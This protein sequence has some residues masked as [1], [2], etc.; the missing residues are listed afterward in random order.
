MFKIPAWLKKL[1]SWA[2]WTVAPAV[3]TIA[4]AHYASPL[5]SWVA[6][7]YPGLG[8]KNFISTVSKN[9]SLLAAL[10]L[11]VRAW[12]HALYQGVYNVAVYDEPMGPNVPKDFVPREIMDD[13]YRELDRNYN[14]YL[15]GLLANDHPD[16]YR[17]DN[18]PGDEEEISWSGSSPIKRSK[19]IVDENMTY[20]TNDEPIYNFFGPSYPSNSPHTRRSNRIKKPTMFYTPPREI[21]TGSLIRERR[22]PNF[23]EPGEGDI[24]SD[25]RSRN[26]PSRK[27]HRAERIL[28]MFSS[29][30]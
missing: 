27:A 26:H 2:F 24:F 17:L 8:L 12:L 6:S 9:E 4:A 29:D 5:A 18:V 16:N 23:K 28:N 19:I 10:P 20:D 25:R 22:R 11:S 13:S 30:L 3:V 7:N 1:G 15:D 21:G 14:D